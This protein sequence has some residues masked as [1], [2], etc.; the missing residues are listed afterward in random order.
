VE[1]LLASSLNTI[2]I[3]ATNV[4]IMYEI[5][6]FAAFTSLVAVV[7]GNLRDREAGL[8]EF[9]RGLEVQVARRPY[10][11]EAV[12]GFPQEAV[13]GFPQEVEGQSSEGGKGEVMMAS[14][15]LQVEEEVAFLVPAPLQENPR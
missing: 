9:R 13:E 7:A 10:Q 15:A 4:Q 14:Y 3:I 5:A 2:D 1:R 12:E 11:K 6:L 8:V